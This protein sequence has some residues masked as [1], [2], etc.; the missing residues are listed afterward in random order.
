MSWFLFFILF[1]ILF[2]SIGNLIARFLI[3]TSS[4]TDNL[5]KSSE[6][7]FH[8]LFQ[9]IVRN[10]YNNINHQGSRYN[11]NKKASSGIHNAMG[12]KEALEILGLKENATEYEIKNSYK[13]LIMK[14]HPDSGGSSYLSQK[15]TEAKKVLLR[16]Q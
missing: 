2:R 10:F 11:G 15:I 7:D 5:K 6:S 3:N 9:E 13:K 12:R 14:N 1:F 4:N 16:E 8:K